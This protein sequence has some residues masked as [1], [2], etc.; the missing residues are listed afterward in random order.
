VWLNWGKESVELHIKKPDERRVLDA[1]IAHPHHG[2]PCVPF[3]WAPVRAA[4]SVGDARK[5][6]QSDGPNSIEPGSAP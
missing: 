3:G 1:M 2:R 4:P 6:G 5:F